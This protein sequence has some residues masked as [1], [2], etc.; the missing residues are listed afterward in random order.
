MVARDRSGGGWRTGENF[1]APVAVGFRG[2]HTGAS[3]H[4]WT[5]LDFGTAYRKKRRWA[6]SGIRRVSRRAPERN[7]TAD[8]LVGGART[9]RPL[10]LARKIA[11]MVHRANRADTFNYGKY[12]ADPADSLFEAIPHLNLGHLDM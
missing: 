2:L 12:C 1:Y 4:S 9:R 3:G 6:P 10:P 8:Q 5:A 11:A 7:A